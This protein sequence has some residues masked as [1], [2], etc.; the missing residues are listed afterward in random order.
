VSEEGLPREPVRLWV[1]GE[2]FR[3]TVAHGVF[4]DDHGRDDGQD[5][6]QRSSRVRGL[7]KPLCIYHGS[8]TDGFTAA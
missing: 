6:G 1:S 5:A 2:S 7:M 8:C 4:A 3:A